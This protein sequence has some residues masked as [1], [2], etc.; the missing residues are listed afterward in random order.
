MHAVSG[1]AASCGAGVER[2]SPLLPCPQARLW[3]PT[4]SRCRCRRRCPMP[5]CACT[6]A[7]SSTG[8]PPQPHTA[9][10]PPAPSPS[11]EPSQLLPRGGRAEGGGRLAAATAR[12]GGAH[13]Q[14]LEEGT[15]P[16]QGGPAVPARVCGRQ[17]SCMGRNRAADVVLPPHLVLSSAKGFMG[18]PLS[19]ALGRW[20]PGSGSLVA[21]TAGVCADVV[22]GHLA[23]SQYW[24]GPAACT[25]PA[26]RSPP[27]IGPSSRWSAA[28]LAASISAPP[29][30][31]IST[32]S[33]L[34]RSLRSTRSMTTA[35][36]GG[37]GGRPGAPHPHQIQLIG[38]A[39]GSRGGVQ[40]AALAAGWLC[41][42]ALRSR[43]RACG[44]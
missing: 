41:R 30:Q 38:T 22:R 8:A 18:N 32:G 44:R 40:C 29:C 16:E 11:D 7:P 1:G 17:L 3:R 35:C 23:S 37:G 33:V 28:R 14:A 19:V 43:P 26:A 34:L 15:A 25:G 13:H 2:A 10:P 39:G 27:S 12:L 36:G 42:S 20:C 31:K 24:S 9:L 4:A 6:A 21:S 5:T